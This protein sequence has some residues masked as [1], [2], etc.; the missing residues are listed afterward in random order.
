MPGALAV[1]RA[2]DNLELRLRSVMFERA[3]LID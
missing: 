2:L 1:Y 3:L